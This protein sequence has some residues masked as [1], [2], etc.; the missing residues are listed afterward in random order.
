MN[1]NIFCLEFIVKE[2]Y[3]LGGTRKTIAESRKSP[4]VM[5]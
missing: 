4:A 1:K 2:C 5:K 3:G